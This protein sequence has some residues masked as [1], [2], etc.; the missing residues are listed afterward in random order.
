MV[1]DV[2]KTFTEKNG[3]LTH[4]RSICVVSDGGMGP[5]A[6]CLISPNLNGNSSKCKTMHLFSSFT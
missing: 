5:P 6:R 1:L 4:S 3:Q 2:L